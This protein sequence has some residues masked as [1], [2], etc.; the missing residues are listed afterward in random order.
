MSKQLLGGLIL[1]FMIAWVDAAPV[2]VNTADAATIAENLKGIGDKKA[3]A[4]VEYREQY[5]SF[6][7]VEQLLDVK[8]IGEQTLQAIRMD[9]LLSDSE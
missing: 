2:N 8:G 6:A 7:T 3:Q 5:G 1:L 4:I 9:V